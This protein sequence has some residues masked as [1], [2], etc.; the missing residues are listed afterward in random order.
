M[1][2]RVQQKVTNEDF[3]LFSEPYLSKLKHDSK[4]YSDV[5]RFARLYF[6][7]HAATQ[8]TTVLTDGLNGM[9]LRMVEHLKDNAKK[10]SRPEEL[11]FQLLFE[12]FSAT[13]EYFKRIAE[14]W[15]D[16]VANGVYAV[17]AS[18]LDAVADVARNR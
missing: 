17:S 14:I 1:A 12:W 16:E 4:L 5:N 11:A 10:P 18:T 15:D 3:D 6:S 13:L 9:H 8:K 7:Y 2:V